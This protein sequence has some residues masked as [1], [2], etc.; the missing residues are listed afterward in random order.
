VYAIGLVLSVSA[1][2]LL[3][4]ACAWYPSRM[5]TRVEPAEA[6]RYE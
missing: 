6:L 1:I 4:L 5:A 2:Y 3:T